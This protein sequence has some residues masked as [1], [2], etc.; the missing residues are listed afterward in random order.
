MAG[1]FY[2]TREVMSVTKKLAFPM[3]VVLAIS[4]TGAAK[5]AQFVSHIDLATIPTL[6]EDAECPKTGAEPLEPDAPP[7]IDGLIG[8][9]TLNYAQAIAN[10]QAV[11]EASATRKAIEALRTSPVAKDPLAAERLASGAMF[12]QQPIAA[13]GLLLVAHQRAP[14]DPLALVNLAAISNYLGL[15]RE[16]LALLGNAEGLNPPNARVGGMNLRAVLLSNKGYALNATGRP[17]EAETALRAAIKFDPDLAE[18]YTNIAYAL[19]DQDKCDLAARFLHAGKTRRPAQVM[20]SKKPAT[21]VPPAEVIDLSRGRAGSL[22]SMPL[23]GDPVE[24]A[25]GPV[26]ERLAK[27]EMQSTPELRSAMERQGK[28]TLA[29]QGQRMTWQDQGAVG[30][31]SAERAEWL[32][33]LSREYAEDVSILMQLAGVP[34]QAG[35]RYERVLGGAEVP[36]EVPRHADPELQP[37]IEAVMRARLE[38]LADRLDASDK[39][40]QDRTAIYRKWDEEDRGCQRQRDSRLCQSAAILRRDTAVCGAAKVAAGRRSGS[41]G[42]FNAAFRDLYADASLRLTAVASYFG[43]PAHHG[44]ANERVKVFAHGSTLALLG[45]VGGYVLAQAQGAEACKAADKRMVDLLFDYLKLLEAERCDPSGSSGK[46]GVGVVEV[47]ANCEEISVTAATPGWLGLFVKVGYE[48]SL[49]YEYV[50]AGKERFLAQQAG[51]DGHVRPHFGE[52][53]AAFDGKLTVYAGGFAKAEVGGVGGDVKSSGFVEINGTGD[54]TGYGKQTEASVS[55]T[56]GGKVSG[57]GEAT[58]YKDRL[59][60]SPSKSED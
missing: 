51:L 44:E 2:A 29:A 17:Q 38:M 55:G 39:F 23:P 1:H 46:I 54:I 14:K 37:K 11:F 35:K 45:Q 43:D 36:D 10:L 25:S 24:A 57:G 26:K 21:R 56:V 34:G 16:A 27:I 50:K 48:Q 47:G 8:G 5:A 40:A 58:I 41:M 12:K 49:R 13:L 7:P 33:G 18:A 9:A 52:Y 28:Y 32:L 4:G 42:A 31:L 53:G 6:Y 60:F 30:R 22:P 59:V 19:G 3:L 20:Q 15:H